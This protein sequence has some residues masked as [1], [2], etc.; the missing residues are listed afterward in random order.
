MEGI[1]S[2]KTGTRRK[3]QTGKA[4]KRGLKTKRAQEEGGVSEK[5]NYSSRNINRFTK[6]VR[7]QGQQ[8][9]SHIKYSDYDKHKKGKMGGLMFRGFRP[10]KGE[11]LPTERAS[12]QKD[13]GPGERKK[14]RKKKR[15]LKTSRMLTHDVERTSIRV[16]DTSGDWILGS[17]AKNMEQDLSMSQ[18][19]SRDKPALPLKKDAKLPTP[20]SNTRKRP[21]FSLA[22]KSQSKVGRQVKAK[23]DSKLFSKLASK[24]QSLKTPR[25]GGLKGHNQFL[26][27]KEAKAARDRTET[28]PVRQMLESDGF[29]GSGKKQLL[30]KSTRNVPRWGYN[31]VVNSMNNIPLVNEL[32][33]EKSAGP[34]PPPNLQP[35][36]SKSKSIASKLSGLRFNLKKNNHS[37]LTKIYSK[38]NQTYTHETGKRSGVSLGYSK[39]SSTTQNPRTRKA[40]H[41]HLK[42]EVLPSPM[43]HQTPTTKSFN[44]LKKK[45]RLGANPSN[46]QIHINKKKGD[47]KGEGGYLQGAAE[48]RRRMFKKNEYYAGNSVVD[49][50]VLDFQNG[51]HTMGEIANERAP[52]QELYVGP[53]YDYKIYSNK[54]LRNQPNR[55]VLPINLP[56]N[57]WHSQRSSHPN[58][59]ELIRIPIQQINNYPPQDNHLYFQKSKTQGSSRAQIRSQLNSFGEFPASLQQFERII[60]RPAN[61][62]PFID[63][64]LPQGTHE[65]FERE[66]E[67]VMINPDM[68][69]L[70]EYPSRPVGMVPDSQKYI[71]VR[72]ES[73]GLVLVKA[74]D[75]HSK[76]VSGPMMSKHSR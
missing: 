63:S 46:R 40:T 50:Q 32:T 33:A 42:H 30:L 1:K 4:T 52:E 35:K 59:Y 27:F 57:S 47:F 22:N 26:I 13:L 3:M 11:G 44:Y 73:D 56:K 66:Y 25:L 64:R 53:N 8:R 75:T 6:T 34:L 16:A 70:N 15:R 37:K 67:P 10:K 2:S 28:M 29:K 43:S 55:P 71:M 60:A 74:R 21:K 65:Y 20:N 49:E 61:S 14:L 24:G 69:A 12:V 72:Q 62:K 31:F 9:P 48:N 38:L 41:G 51:P 39:V 5:K 58:M 19:Q 18:T 76:G 23:R 68:F 36:R 54:N 45:D 7:E 17:Q